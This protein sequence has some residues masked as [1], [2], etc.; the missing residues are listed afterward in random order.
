MGTESLPPI[1][2]LS[3]I[4]DVIGL[5]DAMRGRAPRRAT[6]GAPDVPGRRS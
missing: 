1:P 6:G 5:A 2:D 3:I 4:A